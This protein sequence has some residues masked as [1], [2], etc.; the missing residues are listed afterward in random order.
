MNR[1]ELGQ[2]CEI[3]KEAHKSHDR[4]RTKWITLPGKAK[5]R[6]AMYIGWRTMRN[7]NLKN[8]GDAHEPV[9]VFSQ[10]STVEVWLFVTNPRHNP[11]YAFPEDVTMLK[12]SE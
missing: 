9:I 11:I 2:W 12:D 8:V 10:E 1:P 7:G 5:P 4:D 3:N 6:Q